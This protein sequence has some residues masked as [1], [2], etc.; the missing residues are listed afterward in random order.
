MTLARTR[1][2]KSLRRDKKSLTFGEYLDIIAPYVHS[3]TGTLCHLSRKMPLTA[4]IAVS[5]FFVCR[6]SSPAWG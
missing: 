2:R 4:L 6:A 5:G 1:C 3:Y